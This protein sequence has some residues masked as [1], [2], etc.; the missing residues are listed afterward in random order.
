[1]SLTK[2]KR[3][4]KKGVKG[5]ASFGDGEGEGLQEDTMSQTEEEDPIE[6]GSTLCSP[7]KDSLLKQVNLPPFS[8]TP[9]SS[10]S[11]L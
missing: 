5:R 8:T 9:P 1:M 3:R 2:R 7:L 6:Q 10:L 4:K 11:T